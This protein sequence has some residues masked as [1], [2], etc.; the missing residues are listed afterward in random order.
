M[1]SADFME[2]MNQPALVKHLFL[3]FLLWWA[4]R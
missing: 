2:F 3:L 4:L 1:T